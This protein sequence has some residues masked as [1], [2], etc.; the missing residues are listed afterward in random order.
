MIDITKNEET[1]ITTITYGD[2]F[3]N[4]FDFMKNRVHEAREKN[5]NLLKQKNKKSKN[6][7]NLE[8]QKN[9]NEKKN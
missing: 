1:G 5:Q 4:L 8:N 7:K 9:K 6:Q 2:A 3:N